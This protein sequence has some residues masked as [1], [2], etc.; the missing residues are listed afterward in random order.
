[1]EVGLKEELGREPTVSELSDA[2]GLGMAAVANLLKT[3]KKDVNLNNLAYTPIFFEGND[4]DWI[5]F[6]YHDLS[7]KDKFIF[8][9]KIG[10]CDKEVL[11]NNTIAKRL[12]ISPSTVSQ[13]VKLITEK[14]SHGLSN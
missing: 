5:H 11:D 3:R 6:V 12:G 13:R 4:D 9:H 2:T 14:I 10:Y 8:E 7:D 1:V